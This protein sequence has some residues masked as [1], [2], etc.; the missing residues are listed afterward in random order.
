M[1]TP[2]PQPANRADA[3]RSAGPRTDVGNRRG[4]REIGFVRQFPTFFPATGNDIQW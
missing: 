2:F 3:R 1:T 4:R